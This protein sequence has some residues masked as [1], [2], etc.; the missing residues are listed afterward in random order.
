MAR[1]IV[2]AIQELG[3]DPQVFPIVVREAGVNDEEGKKIF[4]EAGITYFG[5]DLTI[6]EAAAE[7]VKKMRGVS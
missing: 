1:G 3:I 6:E 5:E 2:N 4:Q 7:M